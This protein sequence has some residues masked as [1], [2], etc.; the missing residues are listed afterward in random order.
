[1]NLK[2]SLENEGLSKLEI[3]LH[4]RQLE[5]IQFMIEDLSRKRFLKILSIML[6][7]EDSVDESMLTSEE[8]IWY[9]YIIESKRP[10]DDLTKII[11]EERNRKINKIPEE[12]RD[13]RLILLRFLKPLPKIV[14]GDLKSY[15]PFT[16]E[17]LATLPYVN[18]HSLVDRGVAMEVPG[19]SNFEKEKSD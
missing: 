6:E 17:D 11:D 8:K 14:G 3:Q 18:V 12:K 4:K 16:E 15:G 7:N 10:L 5:R 2:N 13:E 1:M 9:K 19:F